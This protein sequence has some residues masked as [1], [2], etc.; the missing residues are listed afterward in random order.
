MTSVP[1][2][3][4]RW[5]PEAPVQR[6][7]AIG[8]TTARIDAVPKVRGEFEYGSDMWMEGMLYGATL[9][10]PH[11]RARIWSIDTA[12]ALAMPACTPP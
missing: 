3:P 2:S 1:A 6:P 4:T 8:E 11:P 5:R 9:R 10:S 12:P 7:G